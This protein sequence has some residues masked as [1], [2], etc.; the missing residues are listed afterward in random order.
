[1]DDARPQ[2]F[3]LADPEQARPSDFSN[4]LG[5]Q[6]LWVWKAPHGTIVIHVGGPFGEFRIKPEMTAMTAPKSQA[7]ED[8]DADE[9][10]RI[11]VSKIDIN[12][13]WR[14]TAMSLRHPGRMA[15]AIGVTGLVIAGLFAASMSSLDSSMN[16]VATVIVTDFY[17]R[18]KAGV[19]DQAC[20]VLARW[21]TAPTSPL[22]QKNFPLVAG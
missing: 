22:T 20:L 13:L 9:T 18:F 11:E 7:R 17:R 15:L 21:L 5:Y 2:L 6:D 4:G 1:M 16:S 14:I 3:V 10:Y 19:T 8:R 12:V